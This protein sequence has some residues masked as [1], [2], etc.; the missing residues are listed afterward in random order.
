VLALCAALASAAVAPPLPDAVMQD[1]PKLALR[2]G[3]EFRHFG[4]AVYDGWFWSASPTWPG[5]A[6]YALDLHY[7]RNLRGTAIARKSIDEIERLGY[8][9]AEQRARWLAQMTAL[10]PD[11]RRGDR[12]TGVHTPDGATQFFH[13]GRRLGE[14]ADREF[15]HAFLAIW[16]DPRTS[17]DD[18]RL[19]LLGAR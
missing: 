16:L 2:G 6:P 13:N 10:F 9:T 12:M 11:I 17:R 7:H 14:V 19:R 8:G 3:G 5:E 18:F 4:F 15:S 1:A